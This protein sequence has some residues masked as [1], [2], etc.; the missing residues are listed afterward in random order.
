LTSARSVLDKGS[1]AT[2]GKA[3]RFGD[4]LSHLPQRFEF[5]VAVM[6]VV[7]LLIAQ[8]GAMAHAYSHDAAIERSSTHLSNQ[9]SHDFC[10]DCLN[11]APL[12]AA[13]GAPSALPFLE[14]QGRSLPLRAECSS[15]VDHRTDLA[16]RS[17]APPASH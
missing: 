10:S 11:F 8:F 16:F 14:P 3:L 12:L 7:A 9:S 17:R 4:R 6:T 15:L 1:C 13:G 2:I 5:R